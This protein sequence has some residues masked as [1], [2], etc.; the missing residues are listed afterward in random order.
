MLDY[1]ICSVAVYVL[2]DCLVDTGD[3]IIIQAKDGDFA[4]IGNILGV[5]NVMDTCQTYELGH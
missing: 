3:N 4:T 5:T 2:C 1:G